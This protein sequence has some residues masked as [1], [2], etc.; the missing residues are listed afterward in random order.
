MHSPLKNTTSLKATAICLNNRNNIVA[1]YEVYIAAE[2]DICLLKN[3]PFKAQL[4]SM[5]E[6][7]IIS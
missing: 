3:T 4:I 7:N 5:F 1:E 6:G 2:Y